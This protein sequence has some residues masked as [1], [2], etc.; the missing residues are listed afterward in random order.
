M[1]KY[2]RV[3]AGAERKGVSGGLCTVV[4]S[5]HVACLSLPR[6]RVGFV[7]SR[8]AVNQRRRHTRLR[9]R[10]ALTLHLTHPQLGPSALSLT[11][12]NNNHA[13]AAAFARLTSDFIQHHPAPPKC[14]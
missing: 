13:A 10:R 5:G 8:V 3:E 2:G 6:L 11:P 4:P 7:Q 9:L 12:H 14:L 1:K